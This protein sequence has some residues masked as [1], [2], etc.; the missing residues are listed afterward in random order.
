M[1]ISVKNLEAGDHIYVRRKGIMYSHHGIYAGEGAVIHF[2]GSEK[3]KVDPVVKKS[4]LTHFLQGGKLRKRE[5]KNRLPHSETLKIAEGKIT[6]R[7]YSLGFNNCEH[8]ASYCAVG[9]SKSKQVRR[10]IGGLFLIA[11]VV[12]G[13]ITQKKT[14]KKQAG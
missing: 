6:D 2:K 4:N 9:K 3:E 8:F 10:A 11:V 1:E 7:S 13:A 5:Y 14:N 12:T